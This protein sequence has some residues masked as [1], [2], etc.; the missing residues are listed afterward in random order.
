MLHAQSTIMS[1][2]KF[3]A[4]KSLCQEDVYSCPFQ[5]C[6]FFN[7]KFTIKNRMCGAFVNLNDDNR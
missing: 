4:Q 1:K 2:I 5:V 3:E 6:I 7:Y